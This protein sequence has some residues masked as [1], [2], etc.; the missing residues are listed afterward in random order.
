MSIKFKMGT[1]GADT[2]LGSVVFDVGFI[3]GDLNGDGQADFSV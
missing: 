2:L 3:S 1:G